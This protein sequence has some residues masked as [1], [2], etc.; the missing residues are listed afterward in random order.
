MLKIFERRN[1]YRETA[2]DTIPETPAGGIILVGLG[3]YGSGL[4]EYLMQRGRP[5][6]G[7]DFDPAA[8]DKWRA[9]GIPVLYGDIA[10]PELHEHLPLG[11]VRWVVSTVR[12]RDLNLSLLHT[13][14]HR[15][16]DGRIALTA[17]NQEEVTA[18][19]EAGAHL[20]FRPFSDAVEQAADALAYSMDFLPE[21]IDWPIAFLEVRIRSDASVAGRTIRDIPLRSTTG[22]S[23]LAVS[24]AGRIFYE[25]GPDFQIYPGDRLLTIGEPG[26]L[27]EAER[28]L[29]LFEFQADKDANADRFEI[30]EVRVAN[31]SKLSGRS[32]P[33]I[34]FRQTYGVT[35]VGIRRGKEQITT[36]NPAEAVRAGDCLIVIGTTGAIEKIKKAAPL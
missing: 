23:I 35:L 19:R 10:D 18:F 28:M 2:T 9:R 34:R 17:V 30:A 25:P 27:K 32:L 3:N 22:A 15:G 21:N 26:E 11:R 5:V 6:V 14:K 36:I 7:V 1:P 4:A 16:Y 24:R 29:T 8:I 13:L 12:L 31:D 20:I 33:D